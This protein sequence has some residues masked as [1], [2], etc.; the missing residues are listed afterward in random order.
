MGDWEEDWG[1]CRTEPYGAGSPAR[2][3]SSSFMQGFGQ[4]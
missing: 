2:V 1:H 3:R 4:S